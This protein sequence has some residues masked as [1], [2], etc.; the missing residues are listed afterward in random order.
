MKAGN[1]QTLE[2]TSHV[3]STGPTLGD[4][5]SGRRMA[6]VRQQDAWDFRAQ[7]APA[8]ARSLSSAEQ[9]S[10]PPDHPLSATPRQAFPPRDREVQ[11]GDRFDLFQDRSP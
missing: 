11:T 7:E 9:C 10:R 2:K 6:A 3:A 1:R 4:G 8:S 5:L